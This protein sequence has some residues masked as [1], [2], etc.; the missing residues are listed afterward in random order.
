MLAWLHHATAAI[1]ATKKWLP[2]L[3]V[4]A[5]TAAATVIKVRKELTMLQGL[6]C[7]SLT[8]D[9]AI[10]CTRNA[11]DVLSTRLASEQLRAM[12]LRLL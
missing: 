1:E 7:R 6:L 4:E 8:P 10:W 3:P 9:F 11:A 12:L 2:R 5:R